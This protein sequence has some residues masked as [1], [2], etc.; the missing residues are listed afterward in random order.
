MVSLT[1]I[2]HIFFCN[3]P[4]WFFLF[5]VDFRKR[6]G[7]SEYFQCYFVSKY[8]VKLDTI[9]RK[10]Y[11]HTSKTQIWCGSTTKVDCSLL[12]SFCRFSRASSQLRSMVV[13]VIVHKVSSKPFL[14]AKSKS[15]E[16]LLFLLPFFDD[17]RYWLRVKISIIKTTF[18]FDG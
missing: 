2:F 8:R 14:A 13:L 7:Q 11:A 18:I 4:F 1:C 5:L 17:K 3:Q 10:T 12:F 16:K 15:R 9:G 6:N